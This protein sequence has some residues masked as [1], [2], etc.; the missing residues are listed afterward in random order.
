MTTEWQD[1]SCNWHASLR[2]TQRQAC[3]HVSPE[4]EPL[5]IFCWPCAARVC[6]AL[7]AAPYSGQAMA[8]AA[9][10]VRPERIHELCT[11][12][13]GLVDMIP[14]EHY[15]DPEEAISLRYMKKAERASTK[16]AFKQQHK[17]AKRAR[18]DPDRD[19]STTAVQQERDAGAKASTSGAAP[20]RAN[21][22]ATASA[23]PTQLARASDTPPQGHYFVSC[24]IAAR[25]SPAHIL[26]SQ[27]E[28]QSPGLSVLKP[29][30]LGKLYILP[31]R[32]GGA[33]A[34]AAGQAGEVPRAAQ[35][36]GAQRSGYRGQALARAA[37]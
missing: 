11:Y 17:A 1:E 15:L 22:F 9:P 14:A 24:L 29:P 21:I 18:L 19:G 32:Q 10:P 4:A 5:V 36:Q 37:A 16:A 26:C 30:Q 27:R 20:L 34:A 13:N 28:L 25:L 2:Y 7:P 8:V 6:T 12:F 23:Q 31:R 35:G 33:A 3:A